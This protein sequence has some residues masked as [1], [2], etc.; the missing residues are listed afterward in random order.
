MSATHVD[1]YVMEE[2]GEQ[3]KSMLA[4]ALIEEAYFNGRRIFVYCPN[5]QQA[6]HLDELLWIFKPDSFIPHN[7]Q[8]EGPEPPPPVQLGFHTEPRGF[9]DLLMNLTDEVPPFY[10]KFKQVIELVGLNEAEKTIS[11]AHYKHYRANQCTLKTH[12]P[13]KDTP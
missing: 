12:Q 3:A 9:H 7:L 10:T 8:G 5:A 1:F 13:T 11:R 6:E 2:E 4:C